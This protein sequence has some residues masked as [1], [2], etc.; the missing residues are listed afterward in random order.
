MK[1]PRLHIIMPSNRPWNIPKLAPRYL[2][3]MRPHGFELRWHILLQGPEPDPKGCNKINEAIDD[4]R[5]GWFMTLAD[6]TDQHLSLFAR[7]FDITQKN[8]DAGAVVFGQV[9]YGG[10]WTLKAEPA[11]MRPCHV[12]GGQVAWNREFFGDHRFDYEHHGGCAD[13]VLI[14]HLHQLHPERFVFVPE[15]LT[16]FG[17][18]EWT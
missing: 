18:L 14:Q 1:A 7:L 2:E 12:C 6:D 8:P 15:T 11:S 17:S 5:S 4:I 16:K 10:R 13:G 3:K 9:R